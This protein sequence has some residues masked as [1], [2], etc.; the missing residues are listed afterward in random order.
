LEPKRSDDGEYKG[1]HLAGIVPVAGQPLEFNFPWHDSM[2][3]VAANYLAVEHAVY[4]CAMVGCETIWI[5]CHK[6]MQP[7]IRYRL[8]DWIM[9]P[10]WSPAA[11]K[12][13]HYPQ[14]SIKRIPIYYVPIHPKD[15]EKR[16]CLAYSALYGSVRVHNIASQLS[17]WL[18]PEKY[19]VSFPYGVYH[20]NALKK[21]EIRHMIS[22]SKSFYLSHNGK[23]VAD[24]EMLGFT[25]GPEDY[26][27]YRKVIRNG[28]GNRPPGSTWGSTALLPVNERWSARFFTLDKVF[29]PA[30]IGDG[31]VVDLDWYHKID[32]WQGYSE[33]LGSE[34]SKS[35]KRP[36]Y[37]LQY[38][39]LNPLSEDLEDEDDDDCED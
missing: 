33:Y 22:S 37:F 26:A 7:L 28:T 5:V 20:L 36:E 9:D 13:D 16:D 27:K 34:N 1:F 18:T 10:V 39:E 30:T 14:E 24:G 15:R 2:M 12:F 29:G 8:G 17:K 38:H 21:R 11:R 19:Y 32:N 4:E 3:P 31:N 35:I 25:F 6:E 23:T